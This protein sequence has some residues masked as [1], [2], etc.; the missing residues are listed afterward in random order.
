MCARHTSL[1]EFLIKIINQRKLSSAGIS[2]SLF[3]CKILTCLHDTAKN[4][5]VNKWK[6]F[7][8]TLLH[9]YNLAYNLGRTLNCKISVR[10]PLHDTRS[11]SKCGRQRHHISCSNYHLY[12]GNKFD[13]NRTLILNSSLIL[14][15][16]HKFGLRAELPLPA[17]LH[18]QN[19]ACLSIPF[20]NLITQK[21]FV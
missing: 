21:I 7:P 5:L 3:R 19:F 20:V 15:S 17:L 1:Y 6:D 16:T 14:H 2:C 12:N 9:E 10:L 4:A 11:T 8:S 13:L 18:R